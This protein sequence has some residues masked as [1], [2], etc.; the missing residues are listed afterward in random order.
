MKIFALLLAALVL[1]LGLVACGGGDDSSGSTAADGGEDVVTGTFEPLAGVPQPYENVSGEA[2]LTRASGKTTTAISLDG[3]VPDTEYM[4]HLHTGGCGGDDPGGPHFKFDPAGGDEPPNEIH[5]MF[6]SN[7]DGSGKAEVTA[8]QEVPE[9]EAGSVVVHTAGDAMTATAG[10]TQFASL[11]VHEGVDHSEGA[12][13]HG[14]EDEPGH[15][16]GGI[17]AARRA[18]DRLRRTRRR[19]DGNRRRRRRRARSRRSKSRTANRS[20]ASRSWSS[21]PANRSASGSAPTRP[22]R[23]T[24]TATTSPRTCRPAARSSST[25]PAEIEGIFEVELEEL[26]DPDRRAAGQPVSWLPLAHALAARQD[27]PVPAWLFAWGASIVLIV[28]FFALAAAWREPRFERQHWRAL[29]AGFSRAIVSPAG[30]GRSAAWSAS[31]CSASRSTPACAGPKRPI[32]TSPSPSS[33]SPLARLPLLL[34]PA[35]RR[36]PAL[37]PLARARPRRRRRL[38][39]DRR[40]ARRPPRLPGAARP[41]ARRRRPRRRRLAG[42]RLRTSGGVAVGLDPHAAAVAA[43]V[44]SVY[45]L[46]MMA[47]FGVEEWCER[48]EV[49][50]VYFGM[51]SRLG[52]FG[53]R[54]RPA[55][56]PPHAL[57]LDQLGDDPRLGRAWSSPRSRRPASTAP[58]RAP[59][60]ARS[61]PSLAGSATSAST[62][63]A[64]SGSP[65]RSSSCSASP[66]WD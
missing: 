29:G 22:K 18:Q 42:D 4:A 37:Q 43:C 64:R 16:G 10:T 51:F 39:G 48:G 28:S 12:S 33:S 63:T 23:S 21:T 53:V 55:R 44:Y 61:K 56:P 26:R 60:R 47:I 59:S 30:P 45:T 57:R 54:G 1:S 34:G 52:A 38:R 9:G 20:A 17:S 7:G 32:A 25:S 40:P 58:P 11:L 35:R 24:S 19:L 3:L 41:L 65:T 14:S 66:A 49:F 62:P 2:E 6:T 15:D 50:S 36:L 31:S 5:L 8:D 27:L 13:D 46:A